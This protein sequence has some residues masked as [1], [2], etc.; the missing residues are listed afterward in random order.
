MKEVALCS[1]HLHCTFID[2]FLLLSL[3]SIIPPCFCL[4]LH[5]GLVD[6]FTQRTVPM[7]PYNQTET[8]EDRKKKTTNRGYYCN[9][10]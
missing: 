5:F 4:P 3:S 1:V 6:H 9:D 8:R 2:D 7:I 10:K